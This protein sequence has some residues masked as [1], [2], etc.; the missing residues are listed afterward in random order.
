MLGSP[1]P[2]GEWLTLMWHDHFATANSKVDDFALMRRQNDTFRRLA[3]AP[4]GEL[5][6][7]AVRDPRSC[8]TSML[9]ATA[10]STPMRTLPVS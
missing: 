6:G 2:L 5:L 7:A 3:R 1:D 8:S 4:F 10:R 9:R